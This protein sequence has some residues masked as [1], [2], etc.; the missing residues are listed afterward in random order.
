MDVAHATTISRGELL[1]DAR[2][3]AL[4]DDEADL[5]TGLLAAVIR[6]LVLLRGTVQRARLLAEAVDLVAPLLPEGSADVDVTALAEAELDAL[7]SLGE[8]VLRQPAPRAR[9]MVE[10]ATPSFVR[11]ADDAVELMILGGSYDGRPMLPARILN[12]VEV[13]GRARWLRFKDGEAAEDLIR[14]FEWRGLQ[15]NRAS[16]LGPRA[17]PTRRSRGHQPV[18]RTSG[19]LR[20]RSAE[21]VR[22]LRIRRLLRRT[23][24]G[25]SA[26]PTSRTSSAC[27]APSGGSRRALPTPWGS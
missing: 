15:E 16:N 18:H 14:E 1:A 17:D 21:R 26:P 27:A 13:R 23:S 12:R 7:L 8:F 20:V 4:S 22:V 2:H 3:A 5:D 10:P 9:V 25:G 6:R 19:A 24:A 11:P